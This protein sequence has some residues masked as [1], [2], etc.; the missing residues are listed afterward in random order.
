MT[1]LLKSVKGS[2]P[3]R[4]FEFSGKPPGHS[5]VDMKFK[6]HLTFSLYSLLRKADSNDFYIPRE[7]YKLLWKW[8]LVFY[9]YILFSFKL[10]IYIYV[11]A[12]VATYVPK[13]RSIL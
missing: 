4:V 2:I 13:Q 7:A 12:P 1:L 3:S 6:Q 11:L 10:Y 9:I 8:S 5:N